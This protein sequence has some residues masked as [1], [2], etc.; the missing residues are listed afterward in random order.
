MNTRR[1]F[2]IFI[3]LLFLPINESV[4]QPTRGLILLGNFQQAVGASYQYDG[5]TTSNATRQETSNHLLEGSYRFGTDYAL[6]SPHLLKGKLTA[7]LSFSATRFSGTNE[8]SDTSQG[9]NVRYVLDG[10]LLDKSPYPVNFFTSSSIQ[11]VQRPFASSYDLTTDSYGAGFSLRNIFL[12]IQFNYNFTK[13]ETSGLA[14]NNEQQIE[15]F[16]FI[17]NHRVRENSVTVAQLLFSN[18]RSALTG[19]TS[20]VESFST[21][22]IDLTNLLSW[23]SGGNSRN[24]SSGFQY[25]EDSGDRQAT[26]IGYSEDLAWDFG[27]ALRGDLRYSYSYLKVPEQTREEHI[28]EGSLKHYLLQNLRTELAIRGR[29]TDL[30][31]GKE[32]EVE[33][34]VSLD[35]QKKLPAESMLQLGYSQ[36]IGVV[37]RSLSGTTVFITNER[38]VATFLTQIQLLHLHVTAG[39]I[40][41]RNANQAIRAIPYIQGPTG[42]YTVSQIGRVTFISINPT[43]A[44]ADGDILLAD[45]QASVDPSVTYGTNNLSLYGALLLYGNFC[46]IFGSLDDYRQDLMEGRADTANLQQSKSYRA[47]VEFR[48]DYTSFKGEYINYDSTYSVYEAVDVAVRY[49]RDFAESSLLLYLRDRLTNPSPSPS[50]VVI[51]APGGVRAV[52]LSNDNAFSAGSVYRRLFFNRLILKLT[53]DYLNVTGQTNREGVSVGMDL[54][55]RFGKIIAELKTNVHWLTT[56]GLTRRDDYVRLDLTRNF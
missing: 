39:T 26:S 37:D 28:G 23:S 4:A 20:I 40:H 13:S 30:T 55:A 50:T 21:N 51:S 43:G 42:D 10:T 25:Q 11:K 16:S 38:I 3:L 19:Q 31:D 9:L 15:N 8:P 46:R 6:Y 41:L 34:K 36:A 1:I 52:Q 33:G 29:S 5:Q 48:G 24:L 54:Q 12:P 22:K 44:I 14:D 18:N 32:Q 17:A 27:K 53:A 45:Y 49:S 7:D 35:Y 2:Y 47:G 56:G